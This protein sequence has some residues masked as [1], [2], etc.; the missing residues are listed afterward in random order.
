MRFV[1]IFLTLS[2]C[3]AVLGLDQYGIAAPTGLGDPDQSNLGGEAAT[4]LPGSGGQEPNEQP[5]TSGGTTNG[6]GGASGGASSMSSGGTISSGGSSAEPQCTEDVDC[7]DEHDCSIDVCV[8]GT[9]ERSYD[10]ALCTPVGGACAKAK[11]TATGCESTENSEQIDLLM[12]SGSF[13]SEAAWTFEKGSVAEFSQPNSGSPIDGDQILRMTSG[14]DEFGSLSQR[15]TVPSG[16]V[17][18]TV[19]GYYRSFG[20]DPNRLNDWLVVSFWDDVFYG[21]ALDTRNEEFASAAPQWTEFTRTLKAAELQFIESPNVVE[22]D[23]Y[24]ETNQ[25]IGS[26]SYVLDALSVTAQVCSE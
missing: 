9:C 25:G 5:N 24:A 1:G 3:N 15:L 17:S 13:E 7:A 23:I 11:C 22:F 14:A 2:G 12:G 16:T 20:T 18:L 4:D 19:S 21:A 6:S 10:D 8:M 26:R